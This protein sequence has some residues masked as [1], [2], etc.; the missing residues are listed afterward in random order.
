MGPG[1]SATTVSVSPAV[2]TQGNA[3]EITGTVTDQTPMAELKGT[4]A[5]SDASQ[6]LQMEY[7]IQQSVDAPIS[8][9]GV[10]V[11]LFAT[12]SSGATTQIG[13]VTSTGQGI[14]P[15]NVDSTSKRRIRN[16][17][18][19]SADHKHTVHH[20]HKQQSE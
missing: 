15:L 17:S 16:H 10:P 19:I 14:L 18:R 1:P 13:Q 11:T 12:D 6:E 20:Q 4:A 5:V 2:V 9:T 8:T 3:V 7:L